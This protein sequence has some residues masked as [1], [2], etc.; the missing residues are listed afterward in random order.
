MSKINL[1]A[2][3]HLHI[4]VSGEEKIKK[5]KN[6]IDGLNRTL[7]QTE[8]DLQNANDEIWR[9]TEELE[10]LKDSD[11]G[12]LKDK[13][14]GFERTARRGAAEVERMLRAL[15]LDEVIGDSDY[16]IKTLNS[17]RN[18]AMTVG[19]AI[20]NIKAEFKYLFEENYNNNGGLFDAQ[21][22]TS[23]AASLEMVSQQLDSVSKKVT[24][25]LENGVPAVGGDGTS[26]ISGTAEVLDEIRIAVEG[27]S[28]ESRA[29]YEP[30]TQ[31]LV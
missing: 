6:D 25:I 24:A 9:L 8:S 30:I 13:L 2:D 23:F 17:V 4:N 5:L 31:L 12:I 15:K 14:E 22:V 20:S 18:G 27:M 28:E 21:M 16:V 3:A 7:S 1:N 26:G 19:Q 29:A 11:V 10:D